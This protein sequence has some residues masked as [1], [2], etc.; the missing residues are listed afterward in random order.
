MKQKDSG[1][2]GEGLEAANKSGGKTLADRM[3]RR[4]CCLESKALCARARKRTGLTDFGDPPIEPALS[5]LVTSLEQEANLH[6]LGRFLI[7]GHLLGI[8]ESRLRLAEAWRKQADALAA[9]PITRPVFITGM[10]R[11][12]STFLHE[13]LTQDP[14]SRSPRAWEVMFPLP[15]P[16]AGG[17]HRDP[18]VR[19]ADAC[20]WWFRRFAPR[21]DEVYPMRA[22]TPHECV[23]IHSF[24]LLSEEFVT[25]CRVP[26]YEG[27]L[28]SAGLG[29]AYAWQKRFLQHLQSRQPTKRWVLKSPDHVYGLEELFSVF[30]DAIVIQTHR[31]P[32]DV[33]KSSLQLTEVL[34]GLFSR[35]EDADQLRERETRVLAESMDRSIRFRDQHADL[36]DRFIDLH[37]SEFVADPMKAVS[38]IYEHLDCPLTQTAT[39]RMRQL[40]A[41]RSRYR[42]R[43]NPTLADLGLDATEEKRRFQRYCSRFDIPCRQP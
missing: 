7:H 38:R 11:S 12:G 19:R 23:A 37:Y 24:T 20:L 16:A 22:R 13:L 4:L 2:T 18:R 31:D 36:A 15:A 5:T 14:E 25:T 35:P 10:P 30:P 32:L 28:R 42:R 33:L 39:G 26:T 43:H 41:N 34:H 1:Q 29:P 21:A 9:S 40:V 3:G 27:F 17:E 6:P 8:L